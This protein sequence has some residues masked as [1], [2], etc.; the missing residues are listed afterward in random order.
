MICPIIDTAHELQN[1]IGDGN[2]KRVETACRGCWNVI[3]SINAMT[4]HLHTENDLGY[5][6]IKVPRQK[7]DCKRENISVPVF[8]FQLNNKE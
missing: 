8:I 1:T 5:T 7:L 3:L 6:V 4:E 2:L